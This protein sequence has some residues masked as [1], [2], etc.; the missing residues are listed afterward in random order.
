MSVVIII[1]KHTY[2][3]TDNLPNLDIYGVLHIGL[4]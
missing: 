2:Q 1:I 3:I 4:S